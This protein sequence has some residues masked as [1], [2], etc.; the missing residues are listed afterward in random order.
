MK[1]LRRWF[2]NL[3]GFKT[4][5]IV[6][7]ELPPE[8]R[9]EVVY[10]TV[11]E[12]KF[13][14]IESIPLYVVHVRKH[15]VWQVLGYTDRERDVRPFIDKYDHQVKMTMGHRVRSGGGFN[16]LLKID[17]AVVVERLPT[18]ID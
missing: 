5:G 9:V 10:E 18:L 11:K 16:N 4:G 13:T 1:F 12:V 15:G 3:F 14:D 7:P 6:Q 2:P 17:R 8:R